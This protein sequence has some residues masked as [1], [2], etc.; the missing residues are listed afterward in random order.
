ML[1]WKGGIKMETINFSLVEIKICQYCHKPYL[2]EGITENKTVYFNKNKEIVLATKNNLA[3]IRIIPEI[4]P[5]CFKE[6]RQSK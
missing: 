5:K 3:R 2:A 6:R 4:C 1:I